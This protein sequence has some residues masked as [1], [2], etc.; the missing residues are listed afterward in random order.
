MLREW[1]DCKG[2][3]VVEFALISATVLLLIP[4]IWDIASVISSSMSLSG[5][6]RA[7]IQLALVQPANTP[8]IAN[9]IQTASGFPPHS[10]KVFTA[11]SCDCAGTH[12]VCGQA[13]E[14]GA[15]PNRYLTI[16]A[17]YSVPTIFPYE[18]YPENSYVISRTATIRVQ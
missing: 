12:A 17:R 16:T 9:V 13:C 4:L 5:G 11:Q 1:C 3:A 8:G 14:D 6:L 10:V 15:Y 7:G 2:A 18:N